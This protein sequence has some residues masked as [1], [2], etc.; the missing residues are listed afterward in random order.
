[1][2]PETVAVSNRPKYN[3]AQSLE[4]VR[5]VNWTAVQNERKEGATA[6]ELSK[7]YG[8]SEPSIYK[9]TKVV[10][11]VKAKSKVHFSQGGKKRVAERRTKAA[12]ESGP[13][14]T[15]RLIQTEPATMREAF[16]Q[17]TEALKDVVV[18]FREISEKVD[19]LRE[20]IGETV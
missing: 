5:N 7:K 12:G 8:V 15:L 16:I 19:V 4:R 1:M 9:Y 13:R 17:A 20:A 10:G 2:E 14:T 18:L 6:S 3:R 11:K